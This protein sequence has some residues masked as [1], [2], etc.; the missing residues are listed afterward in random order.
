MSRQIDLTKKLSDEDREYFIA[1]GEYVVVERN[2][3]QFGRDAS[4]DASESED[5]VAAVEAG[6]GADSAPEK[7]SDEW[8]E[9]ATVA[10]LQHELEQRGLPK[11]GKRA[12]LADRLYEAMIDSGEIKDDEEP[13]G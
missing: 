5:S 6:S 1:R 11:T 13:E 2:D 4:K 8:F 3:A 10:E 7:Y 9:K 12:D